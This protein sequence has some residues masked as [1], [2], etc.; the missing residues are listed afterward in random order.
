MSQRHRWMGSLLGVGT[1]AAVSRQTSLGPVPIKWWLRGSA[2]RCCLTC[3]F[4]SPGPCG[5]L[6]TWSGGA[7]RQRVCGRVR[8]QPAGLRL[9]VIPCAHALSVR[10]QLSSL[11]T[12]HS[13]T[14]FASPV[15]LLRRLRR[16]LVSHVCVQNSCILCVIT[17]FASVGVCECVS[18]NVVVLF[19][20]FS[21]DLTLCGNGAR[22][23]D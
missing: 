17:R 2:V 3:I 10:L 8:A 4:P 20:C 15:L 14:I 16:L 11:C 13:V 9:R 6:C 23:T 21:S 22:L 18:V 5:S 1:L 19:C 12:A 7:R